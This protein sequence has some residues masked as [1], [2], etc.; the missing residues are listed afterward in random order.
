MFQTLLTLT[1]QSN[2]TKPKLRGLFPI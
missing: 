1:L 2:C